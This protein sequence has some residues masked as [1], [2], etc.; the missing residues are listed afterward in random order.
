MRFVVVYNPNS[1]GSFTRK[2]LAALF[3]KNNIEIIAWVSVENIAKMLPRY[4]KKSTTIAVVG[5]DGTISAVAA[6]AAG[7]EA[8]VVPLPGGTLNHFTK[9]LGIDQDINAAIIGLKKATVRSVDIAEVNDR[10]FVN[11]SSIGLYPTSLRTRGR[12]ESKIGKWPAA[13]Y[14]ACRAMMR[15]RLFSVT[16]GKETFHTPFV[17]IG[18]NSYELDRIGAPVRTKL[19]AGK[20]S[21][22]VAKTSSRRSLFK[23]ALFALI[24]R[25]HYINEFD[26]YLV[27]ELTIKMKRHHVHVSYDGEVATLKAPLRYKIHKKE[28]KVLY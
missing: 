17:F 4:I 13:V 6:L 25:A 26:S 8:V 19:N 11:N 7:S 12:L 21:V 23:I 2:L 14:A 15:L 24:G 28:L 3:K 9:D 10:R 16:I 22:F 20:L 18:N 27:E 5:G 1:G